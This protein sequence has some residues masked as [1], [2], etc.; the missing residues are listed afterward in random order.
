[1]K[2]IYQNNQ[3]SD[4]FWSS[5]WSN[6][7]RDPDNISDKSIY[8]LFPI[9]EYIIPGM[10][11]LEAGCGMGR[12]LKHYYYQNYFIV[13][14]ENFFDCL[15]FLIKEQP[16]FPLIHGDIRD[17][18]LQNETMDV[19]L[20]F[21]SISCLEHRHNE[22]LVEMR[23]VLKDEGLIVV[24]AA[25]DNI[26]RRFQNFL[27]FCHY[28]LL[29]SFGKNCQRNF[30]SRAFKPHELKTYL[31]NE[32]FKVIRLEPAHSKIIFWKFFSF[33]RENKKENIELNRDGDRGYKLNS[34]GEMIFNFMRTR[35]PWFIAVGVSCV[36]RKN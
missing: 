28:L 33:L 29:K 30:F 14:L 7:S 11:I 5:Y 10:K 6:V 18:P 17:L 3:T 35:W 15:K 13:G 25:C 2:I 12:V 27:G 32:G 19:V 20:C 8:P 9:D 24:G 21:G 23:R 34:F 26:L 1:M 16:S 36:A 4:E 31:E 22:A